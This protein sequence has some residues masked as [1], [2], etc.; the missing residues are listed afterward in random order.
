MCSLFYEYSNL[1]YGRIDVIY[2]VTQAKYGSFSYG[3]VRGIREYLFN[4]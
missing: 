1:E 3:C 4:T 2:R